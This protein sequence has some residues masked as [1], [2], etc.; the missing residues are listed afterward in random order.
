MTGIERALEP[1]T[2]V[3][4]AGALFAL[5]YINN[6]KEVVPIEKRNQGIK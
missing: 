4:V 6:L 1:L 2:N 3:A 5:G